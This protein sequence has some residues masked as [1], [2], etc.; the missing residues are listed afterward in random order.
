MQIVDLIPFFQQQSLFPLMHLL[1]IISVLLLL[2]PDP[3][4][5]KLLKSTGYGTYLDILVLGK[6][7]TLGL[8]LQE[9]AGVPVLQARPLL[10]PPPAENRL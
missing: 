7:G 2:I 3:I 4:A 6:L 10:Y 5:Y 8:L 1:N 9:P